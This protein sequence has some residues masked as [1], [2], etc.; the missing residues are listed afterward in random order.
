MIKNISRF[1][2]SISKAVKERSKLN[3]PPLPLNL[4]QVQNLCQIFEENKFID[5]DKSFLLDQFKNRII[6]GVDE[7]SYLKANFLIEF[8]K[9][10]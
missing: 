3:I 1:K 4:N 6:P 9:V 8:V 7:T 2:T 10:R 5:E